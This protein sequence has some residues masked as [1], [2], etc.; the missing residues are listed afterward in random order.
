MKRRYKTIV[1]TF[2][3]T[4]LALGLSACGGGGGDKF[5]IDGTT[6]TVNYVPKCVGGSSDAVEN[7]A[8]TVASGTKI[9]KNSTDASLRIWHFKN[10]TKAV[11]LISGEAIIEAS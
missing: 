3:A 1:K 4:S 11:C 5:G 2:M 8:I 6:P 9:I 10:S 7:E